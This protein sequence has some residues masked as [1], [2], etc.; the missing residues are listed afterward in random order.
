MS[1]STSKFP[2]QLFSFFRRYTDQNLDDESLSVLQKLYTQLQAGH[3]SIQIEPSWIETIKSLEEQK[4][5]GRT[6]ENYPIVRTDEGNLYFQRYYKYEANLAKRLIHWSIQKNHSESQINPKII[7]CL[8]NSP[9][10]LQAAKLAVQNSFAVITGGPGTGKTYLLV[11]I[12]ANLLKQNPDLKI[13]LVAPTGKAAQRMT[14]SIQANIHLFPLTEEEKINFPQYASTIHRLLRS[15]PPSIHFRKN[16]DSQLNADFVIVDEASMVDLPLMSKLVDSIKPN[17]RLLLIGDIDQLSPVEAGAPLA[18][19]VSY[20][21]LP[22]KTQ[23]VAKLTTNRRF[24]RDS[25]INKLCHAISE[26]K[27]KE[28]LNVID[29]G[30]KEDFEFLKNGFFDK[31]DEIIKNGYFELAQA[32][33]PAEAH[34][35]F[36]KFQILCP[37]HEGENGVNALN[38]KTQALLGIKEDKN[39]NHRYS[40]MPIIIEQNDYGVDLFNGDIGIFLPDEKQNNQLVAWFM[41]SDGTY[42]AVSA[43]RLPPYK[44]AYAMTVHRSQGSEYNQVMIM[45]PNHH[46]EILSRHLLYV[47]C[48]RARQK[49]TL[50]GSPKIIES[51]INHY[52]PNSNGLQNR[53]LDAS[54]QTN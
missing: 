51:C 40:G 13:S 27:T 50:I 30:N 53:L 8:K 49:V 17:S 10:Q 4:I 44:L 31:S 3:A 29:E 24:G 12:L 43:P 16:K 14:E 26:G 34:D 46:T 41:R 11:A 54:N 33:T 20:F 6:N 52:T 36:L 19:V 48:S 42:R 23:L 35:A 1:E 7:D 15:L 5:V 9:D 47:A 28:V 21:L 38:Q 2:H 32:K 37:T 25:T 18:S 45:L 39:N 22:E